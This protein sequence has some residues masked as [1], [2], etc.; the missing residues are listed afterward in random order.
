MEGQGLAGPTATSEWYF[1]TLGTG[2]AG[3]GVYDALSGWS[4]PTLW[5]IRDCQQVADAGNGGVVI[6]W[7]RDD[8]FVLKV[9]SAA[10]STTFRLLRQVFG[11]YGW[12]DTGVAAW[13]DSLNAVIPG[14][15]VG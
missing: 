15:I 6:R 9:C 1:A 3:L 5:G 4:H 7:V 8:S 13:A 14:I 2:G 10:A 11:F 12:D